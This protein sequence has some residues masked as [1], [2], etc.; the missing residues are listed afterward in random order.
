MIGNGSR[1]VRTYPFLDFPA[2]IA[3][4]HRGGSL[5]AEENTLPAFAHAVA[6]GYSHVELDV[7]A[8]RD[9]V[10][11][12]HHDPT[13]TRMTGDPRAI[14]E[15]TWDE[16]R[17]VRTLG[18][19]QIPRL[20]DLFDAQPHLFVNIEPKSDLVVESLA[21]LIQKTGTLGRIAVGSFR[22]ERIARLRDYLG[23]DLC[24]SPAWRGVLA[25][26]LAGLG[27]PMGRVSEPMLQV[28]QTYRGIPVVVPGFVRAAHRMGI[29]VQVWT[30]NDGAAMVHLLDMGVD[31]IMT[32]RPTLLRDILK[33]R[34][35]WHPGTAMADG[36]P[37]Q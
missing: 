33:K 3:I 23:P 16:L 24:R 7:H 30:V 25:V 15:M 29:A 32:D 11:V 14:A 9:G 8:T 17:D 20:A 22:A 35:Q 31:A 34:G 10:V 27:L 18:G 4:A 6:L 37:T 21:Q 5:E 12:V 28:P 26:R 1:M 2:P 36:T 13:L 19:A